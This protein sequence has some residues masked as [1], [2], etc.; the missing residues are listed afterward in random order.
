[1]EI[2]VDL[3]DERADALA[4]RDREILDATDDVDDHLSRGSLEASLDGGDLD[5]AA[6][7]SAAAA[8]GRCLV[9]RA[10]GDLDARHFESSRVGGDAGDR[11]HVPA[12]EK[13]ELLIGETLDDGARLEG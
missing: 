5:G 4:D 10:G 3:A 2:G 12:H 11:R 8:V 9:A 1:R 7:R 6:G 13:L